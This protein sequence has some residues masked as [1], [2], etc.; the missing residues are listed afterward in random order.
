MKRFVFIMILG[1]TT[2]LAFSQKR[3]TRPVPSFTGIEASSVFD[4]TV[5]KGNTESLVI[6]A[7]EAAMPY[8]ISEV[9]DGVLYLYFDNQEKLKNIIILKAHIVMKSLEQVTLSGASKLTANDLFISDKFTCACGGASML[10]VNVNTGQLSIET[11][12]ACNIRIKANVTGDTHFDLSGT[13]KIQGELKAANVIFN[14]SGVCS[15]QLTGSAKNIEMDASGVSSITM[16]DFLAATAIIRASGSGNITV[17][18]SDTLKVYSS[19]AATVYYKGAP[20]I[21]V[22]N[23]MAAKVKKIN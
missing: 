15:V 13:S 20:S 18:V 7:D 4:I 17:N 9:Q 10:S 5:T 22:H 16:K 6:E 23:S 12:G 14:S 8:I 2:M 19:G 11:S 1:L 21:E 3:E